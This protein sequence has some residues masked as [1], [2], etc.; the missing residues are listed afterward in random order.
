M[1]L[2]QSQQVHERLSEKFPYSTASLVPRGEHEG[3]DALEKKLEEQLGLPK[4]NAYHSQL[5]KYKEGE[6]VSPG[7][8]AMFA[9]ALNATCRAVR[10][11]SWLGAEIHNCMATLTI[12][13]SLSKHL[14]PMSM[15]VDC[16]RCTTEVHYN[17]NLL[18]LVHMT[19]LHF[20]LDVQFCEARWEDYQP[21]PWGSAQGP[22]HGFWP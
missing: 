13:Q 22:F 14:S 7:L 1:F 10:Q 8:I 2:S 18:S 17:Y 3:L 16:Y 21:L 19:T 15:E 5:I 6:Q 20:F 4:D 11:H 9:A 12:L